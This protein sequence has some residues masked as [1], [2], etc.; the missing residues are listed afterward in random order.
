MKK[1]MLKITIFMAIGFIILTYINTHYHEETHR[2][3][4]QKYGCIDDEVNLYWKGGN[5][6]CYEYEERTQ[7]NTEDELQLHMMNEIVT[8]NLNSI[9]YSIFLATMGII[10]TMTL[11][12]KQKEKNKN[13]N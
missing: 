5:F 13:E 3:I 1:T 4:A 8:Y 11:L 12:N 6:I 7:K 9:S 2:Q 10:L